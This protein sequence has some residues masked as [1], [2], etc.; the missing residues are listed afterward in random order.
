M[1]EDGLL[2]CPCCDKSNVKLMHNGDM[3]YWVIC[4]NCG[5][6][7]YVKTNKSEAIAVWNT[8]VFPA[9]L[10]DKITK[11]IFMIE[12]AK[13]GVSEEMKEKV[14]IAINRLRW[15]LSLTPGDEK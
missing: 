3:Q 7:T 2:E 15:V 12:I 13:G 10:R 14:D 8:R 1:T 11:E 4:A 9:W 5:I 6:N